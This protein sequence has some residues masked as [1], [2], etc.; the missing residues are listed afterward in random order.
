MDADQPVDRSVIRGTV[1]IF[2][3]VARTLIDTGASHSF[4]SSTLARTMSLRYV[5]LRT[6][7]TVTT[8]VQENIV[9]DRV[10]RDCFVVIAGYEH[11]Y[12]FILLDMGEP[13][14]IIGMDWLTSF[15]AVID[16]YAH[17]MTFVTAEG[18]RLQFL[19][20]RLSTRRTDPLDAL[21]AS[22]WA[23]DT[24][25]QRSV[26]P[27]VVREYV[28]V[29]PE[30]L[31][32]LPPHREVEF[33]IDIVQGTAPIALPMYRMA[34]AEL[35]EMEVQIADLLRL[36]FIRR[37]KSPWAAP[38]LFAKK[39]DGTLRLCIDYR[40]L[41]AVTVKNKYPLPRI[42]DLFD[43]L[44]GARCFSKIDLRSGY[45]QLLIREEDIPKTAFRTRRGLYEFVV[46]PFG[47]TNAPAAFMDL[48][49]RVF[50]DYLDQFIIVFVDD[51][52]IYSASEADHERH[53]RTALQTLREHRLYAKFSKCEF[54][55]PEVKFLGHVV[56]GKVTPLSLVFKF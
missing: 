28:D 30:E 53:L 38:A 39:K 19:G 2:G 51:I 5:T 44:W 33:T 49:N 54:W 24:G 47:L 34:P 21:I 10:C 42:D 22:I 16:C 6:P 7:L 52:L 8:P 11:T 46:M 15:R 48:M 27:R 32:G 31:P 55:L 3:S 23:E 41:N 50:D 18:T 25:A 40:K 45:H 1:L 43:Q 29:F 35:A 56:S 20:D 14:V 26:F 4:I 36:G 12:D 17:S 37:S 13:D 9:L